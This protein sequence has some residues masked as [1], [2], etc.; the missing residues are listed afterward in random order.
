MLLD[1]VGSLQL[2][3]PDA[4]LLAVVMAIRAA[5][6]GV[7]NVT[8][9]DLAALRLSDPREAVHVLRELG[10]QMGDAIFDS[11]PA[12]PPVSVTVPDL[13]GEAPRPL[14][15]G[16]TRRSRVSGWTIRTLSAKPVKKLPSAARLAGLFV[17]AHATSNASRRASARHP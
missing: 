17:A 7:G 10:R 12:A 15:F 2:P 3:G 8:G 16:K 13:V 5:R 14:P 4:Q 11:D 6:R 9:Q 1:Y